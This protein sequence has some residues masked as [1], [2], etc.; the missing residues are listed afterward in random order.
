MQS[1]K[2]WVVEEFGRRGVDGESWMG[3]GGW[4]RM[5]GEGWIG[6]GGW[7]GMDGEG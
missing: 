1:S 3:K 4:G 7:G 2:W 6:K 5:D